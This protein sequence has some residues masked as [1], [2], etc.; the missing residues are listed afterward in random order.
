MRSTYKTIKLISIKMTSNFNLNLLAETQPSIC[1]PR[2]FNNITDKKIRQVFDELSLGKISRIDIVK[3]RKNEKGEVF[4]RV[5]IHFEKWFWNED[6]Q[7]ARR[8][9]ILGK[10][11][12]I[13]YDNPWF[14]KVSASKWD[15]STSNKKLLLQ[16]NL[17]Q[18]QVK[19]SSAVYI[20]FDEEDNN[21]FNTDE[22]GRE[23]RLSD[24]TDD[25]N[26]NA[27]ADEFGR[28]LR[29]SDLNVTT[30]EFGRDLDLKRDFEE[31]RIDRINNLIKNFRP[32]NRR[33]TNDRRSNRR[34]NRRSQSNDRRSQ[35]NDRRSN[36][37]RRPE[38]EE[39]EVVEEPVMRPFASI[40]EDIDNLNIPKFEIDYGAPLPVPKINRK[41]IKKSNVSVPIP[42]PVI[43]RSMN[44]YDD[45]T[46]DDD[47][48]ET[49]DTDNF[50]TKVFKQISINDNDNF[51]PR[52]PDYPPPKN[53]EEEPVE[54]EFDLYADLDL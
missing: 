10:E 49:N 42:I 12:K 18:K 19:R 13:I 46:D 40:S 41:I 29:L 14:W 9:L 4:N 15:P 28:E 39:L 44:W 38:V 8:K 6:A 43:K 54:E 17:S 11:I 21:K 22:F 36:D 35:S 31:R 5:Y 51:R 37:R 26:L 3:E 50:L 2:V 24:L 27:N 45:D 32:I 20:K 47:D 7:T 25:R 48:E 34:S 16:D 30:D 33:L 52:S 23:L 1:I 53:Q